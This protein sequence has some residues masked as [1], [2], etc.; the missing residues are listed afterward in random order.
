MSINTI[1]QKDKTLLSR[2]GYCKYCFVFNSNYK[3]H[4]KICIDKSY[5][6][7]DP[8]LM[9]TINKIYR[10]YLKTN[11][12]NEYNYNL[13]L[14]YE[15]I[16]N[17]YYNWLALIPIHEIDHYRKN[18][19]KIR[20]NLKIKDITSNDINLLN[21]NNSTCNSKDK[22][23]L[24]NKWLDEQESDFQIEGLASNNEESNIL[25]DKINDEL[26]DQLIS[27]EKELI[28]AK[29]NYN[30]AKIKFEAIQKY[31]NSIIEMLNNKNEY[32][33]LSQI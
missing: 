13:E 23:A 31:R 20:S 22:D 7:L 16:E 4:E 24:C 17:N 10:K 29:D 2:K 33:K 15:L 30:N 27:I 14:V 8:E 28:V 11:N 18:I 25:N 26:S 19:N 21:I 32:I 3:H 5:K 1:L 6:A 9:L 12:I